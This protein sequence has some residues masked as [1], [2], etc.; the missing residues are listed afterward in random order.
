[1]R[2]KT[3]EQSA[4]G[5]ALLAQYLRKLDPAAVKTKQDAAELAIRTLGITFTVY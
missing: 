5:L 4:A 1:M 3:L 2:F